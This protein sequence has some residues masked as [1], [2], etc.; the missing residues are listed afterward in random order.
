VVALL[1]PGFVLRSDSTEVAEVFELPLAVALVTRNYRLSR[2]LV[3]D[4][5]VDSWELAYGRYHIWGA[6][7]GML[8]TLSELMGEGGV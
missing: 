7:A 3:R 2:R 4:V 5:E 6:T 1:Q 8:M